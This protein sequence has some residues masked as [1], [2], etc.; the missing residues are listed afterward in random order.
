[1]KSG[2]KHSRK[3][4]KKCLTS[5]SSYTCRKHVYYSKGIKV[6]GRDG[7]LK[8]PKNGTMTRKTLTRNKHGRIVSKRKSRQ[9]SKTY[10]LKKGGLRQWNN[11]AKQRYATTDAVFLLVGNDPPY[12]DY[13]EDDNTLSYEPYDPNVNPRKSTRPRKPIAADGYRYHGVRE[14]AVAK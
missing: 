2:S 6:K 7:K 3:M 5:P 8:Q 11:T 9:S 10:Y 1:M 14:R 13:V 12:E 4:L